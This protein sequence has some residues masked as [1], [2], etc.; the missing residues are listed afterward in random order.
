MS[1]LNQSDVYWPGLTE[2]AVGGIAHI[3]LIPAVVFLIIDPYRRFF[4]VRFHSWQ[5]IFFFIAWALVNIEVGIVQSMAP[6]IIVQT[7]SPLQIT[8]LIFFVIWLT[9]FIDAFNGKPIKLS[10]VGELAEKQTNR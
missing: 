4:F 5:S 8:G 2:N 1:D 10:I 3:T 6:A 7:L 9:V